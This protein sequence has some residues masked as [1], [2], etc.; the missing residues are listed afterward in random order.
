MK[1]LSRDFSTREKVLIVI[2]VAI[3]IVLGYYWLVDTPVRNGIAEADAEMQSAELELT[4]VSAKIGEMQ[5][6]QAELDALGSE[7]R[8]ASMASYN[9]SAAEYALRTS[10]TEQT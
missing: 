8:G 10:L 2:L 9:N 4:A 3:L 5:R 1:I 6:M 7:G